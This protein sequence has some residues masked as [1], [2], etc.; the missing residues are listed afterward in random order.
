MKIVPGDSRA[1]QIIDK[2]IQDHL[3][4]SVERHSINFGG[5]TPIFVTFYHKTP[6]STTDPNLGNSNA[7][8]GPNSPHRYAKI[9]DFPLFRF[10]A[11]YTGLEHGD[12]GPESKYEG[13]AVVIP[14]MIRPED[15]DH[16]AVEVLSN[17]YLFRITSA[18]PDRMHTMEKYW[19]IMYEL[20]GDEIETIN[21]QVHSDI[22]VYPDPYL[23][24]TGVLLEE[25]NAVR[26]EIA[27]IYFAELQQICREW[28][29]KHTVASP[30][31]FTNNGRIPVLLELSHMIKKHD[32]LSNPYDIQ[33]QLSLFEPWKQN[34]SFEIQR[35]YVKSFF[36]YF[37]RNLE[38]PHRM[39][40]V[41]TVPTNRF[42]QPSIYDNFRHQYGRL[43]G[44]VTRYQL[45]EITSELTDA[46]LTII[47]QDFLD[48]MNSGT[49]YA[50]KSH[51][52]E[53]ILITW[54][55]MGFNGVLDYVTQ[56]NNILEGI[57]ERTNFELY[58][59]LP[60]TI[61]VLANARKW[62]RSQMVN[63]L[64]T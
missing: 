40:P 30:E 55:N 8:V 51:V 21:N 27:E 34:N 4:I 12:L 24:G 14:G 31:K 11:T 32:L 64:P 33:S 42:I 39:N 53:N 25:N 2:R 35:M 36:A 5:S 56:Q 52:L 13:E 22:R 10:E 29:A 7:A 57:V 18:N 46:G 20:V 23:R 62:L 45:Y 37:D 48:R 54:K 49:L 9:K 6:S 16:F 58:I 1:L 15:G 26:L 59:L 38:E 47:T 60:P 41:P 3:R 43:M 19:K 44:S 28:F 17:I 61:L 50:E 63:F